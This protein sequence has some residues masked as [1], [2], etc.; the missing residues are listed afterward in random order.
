ML[1][2]HLLREVLELWQKGSRIHLGESL[3][4]PLSICLT[5]TLGNAFFLGGDFSCLLSSIIFPKKSGE[6]EHSSECHRGLTGSLTD[7]G[8]SNELS[9]YS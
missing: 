6:I 3:K 2:I 7:L 9:V 4:T 1:C 5:E 8:G